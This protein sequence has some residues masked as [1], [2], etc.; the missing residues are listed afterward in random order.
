ML[1]SVQ[2]KYVTLTAESLWVAGVEGIRLL[3]SFTRQ[4]PNRGFSDGDH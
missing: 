3:F 1:L 4:H 2:R